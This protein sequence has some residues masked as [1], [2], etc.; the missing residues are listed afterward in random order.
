MHKTHRKSSYLVGIFLCQM[1]SLLRYIDQIYSFLCLIRLGHIVIWLLK[2]HRRCWS[3]ED[4]SYTMAMYIKI[5]WKVTDFRSSSSYWP[6]GI[7]VGVCG[8]H[9][10]EA[11]ALLLGVSEAY[12]SGIT[13][14]I[15]IGKTG[16]I[17]MCFGQLVTAPPAGSGGYHSVMKGRSAVPT[18]NTKHGPW[19]T[20]IHII[21]I[22][23][24]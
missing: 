21:S 4:C 14:G 16:T 11:V 6:W 23:F 13:L 22:R 19:V 15:H 8:S 24:S 17:I 9:P 7:L 10:A 12:D 2:I 1:S 20:S 18:E 5:T 3:K